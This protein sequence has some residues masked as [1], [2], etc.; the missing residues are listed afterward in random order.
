[1]KRLSLITH[2]YNSHDK[3]QH[4]LDH[5]ASISKDVTDQIEIIIVDDCSELRQPLNSHG[6][7]LK[8]LRVLDDIPW[9]Q[10]GARN[11]GAVTANGEWLLYFD[12]DQLI[13]EYGLSYVVNH[14]GSLDR[15]LMYFFL[16]ENFV[17]SNINEQLAVHPNTFLVNAVQFRIDGMYD[18]DFAG[19][20]GYEDIYLPYLWEKN[21]GMR[22]MI[23]EI[24]FFRDQDFKTTSLSRDLEH[25]KQVSRMKFAKGLKRPKS[26]VRFEWEVVP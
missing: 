22:A 23:G 7:D 18:E 2:H 6:L 8:H 13:S 4:L 11:L 24:P 17:D 12:M 20:Y 5:L 1:M 15:R 21:G 16:V 26:F 14:A 3:A 10:A 25:N 9:N 19:H